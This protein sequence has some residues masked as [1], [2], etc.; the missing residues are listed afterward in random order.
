MFRCNK[1]FLESSFDFN[2]IEWNDQKRLRICFQLH[3]EGRGKWKEEG[4]GDY[5]GM[6]GVESGVKRGVEREERRHGRRHD[7]KLSTGVFIPLDQ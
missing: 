5:R 6:R 2:F 1:Q 3:R 7:T 4:E